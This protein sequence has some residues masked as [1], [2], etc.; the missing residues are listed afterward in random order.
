VSVSCELVAELLAWKHPGFSAHAGEPIAPEQKQ[1]LEDT[2]AYLVRA[3]SPFF[4]ARVS[5]AL[6][7]PLAG[8]HDAAARAARGDRG[9]IPLSFYRPV[10]R[11]RS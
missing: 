3:S 11:R 4:P 7:F 8:S 6:P 9:S 1:H 10:A 2:A 5:S